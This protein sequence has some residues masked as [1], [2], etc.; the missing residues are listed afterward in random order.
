V[1]LLTPGAAGVFRACPVSHDG[2][3]VAQLYL[4][5][6]MDTRTTNR[7]DLYE[8]R[9]PI[10]AQP[11]P[12]DHPVQPD[13]PH[14]SSS[15]IDAPKMELSLTQV[16][17]GSLA[18]A[19]AAA[20]GSRLGVVGTITGAALVSVVASV[21]G[22]VYTASLRR[23]KYQVSRALGTVAGG[24]HPVRVRPHVRVVL[25]GAVVVFALTAASVTGIELLTGSSLSG[26]SG[27]T[28]V[29][30]S[31]H[32]DSGSGSQQEQAPTPR[33]PASPSVSTLP[34]ASLTPSNTVMPSASASATTSQTPSSAASEPTSSPTAS[35]TPDDDVSTDSTPDPTPSA[36]PSASL[37]PT[38]EPTSPAQSAPVMP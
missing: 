34:S 6:V 27:S 15:V 5:A 21:A 28:T 31:L 17:G 10:P 1:S 16:L 22:A 4:K 35:A 20:L 13:E 29:S 38:A 18:A 7:L 11:D 8:D 14:P 25:L 12:L 23:T 9:D 19:T 26:R 32:A 30:T 37:V 33:T 2:P 3:E 24:A 36:E